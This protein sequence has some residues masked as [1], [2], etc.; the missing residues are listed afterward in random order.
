M[1]KPNPIGHNEVNDESNWSS[2]ILLG[3]VLETA[4]FTLNWLCTIQI[5]G[6]DRHH[7]RYE[8]GNILVSDSWR[9]WVACLHMLNVWCQQSSSL[10]LISVSICCILGKPKGI[11]S[12]TFM[13]T[14]FSLLKMQ[15]FLRKS[16][17]KKATRGAQCDSKRFD[18]HKKIFQVPLMMRCSKMS[19]WWSLTN[20]LNPDH[21]D[22]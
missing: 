5:C 15:S 9:F 8:L 16:F 4:T 3:Y 20:M 6:E 14:K 7:I 18:K 17:S 19:Q 1:E 12:I 13:R 11:I 22:Q 10:D 2:I 21:E